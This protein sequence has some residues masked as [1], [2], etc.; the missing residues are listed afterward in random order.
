MAEA[1]SCR[2][3]WTSLWVNDAAAC[4]GILYR[5]G[6]GGPIRKEEN[7]HGA[8]AGFLC[9]SRASPIYVCTFCSKR[10][11]KTEPNH[12]KQGQHESALRKHKRSSYFDIC[13]VP[14]QSIIALT[15]Y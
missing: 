10:M 8:L 9:T 7:A 11:R 1:K 3:G 12:N 2:L 6:S 14:Q 15:L 4:I 13:I 5:D